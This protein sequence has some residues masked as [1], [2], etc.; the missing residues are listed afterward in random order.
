M[1]SIYRRA[2]SIPG[3]ILLSVVPIFLIA[4]LAIEKSR[5]FLWAGAFLHS[6]APAV[7]VITSLTVSEEVLFNLQQPTWFYYFGRILW[8]MRGLLLHVAAFFLFFY[9][10]K[11][12]YEFHVK[13]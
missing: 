4:S 6:I 11:W 1:D 7:V 8:G 5:K 9:A 13:G 10:Y 12:T 3:V 2:I